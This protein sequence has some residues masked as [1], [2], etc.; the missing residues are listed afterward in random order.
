MARKQTKKQRAASLKNLRKARRARRS[1]RRRASHRPAH[2]GYMGAVVATRKKSRKKS[3]KARKSRKHAYRGRSRRI[4]PVVILTSRHGR[5]RFKRPR[6]SKYFKHPT[7][8]N[9]RRRRLRLNPLPS[10]RGVKGLFNLRTITRYAAI[11]GGVWLGAVVSRFLN[12]G[13][14]PGVATPLFTVPDFLVK[15]RPAHGLI[16]IALGVMLQ[17]K[18]RNPMLKDAGVGLAALGGFDLLMQVLTLAGVPNLPVF[19]GM[20]VSM[21]GANIDAMSGPTVL[22]GHDPH[23]EDSLLSL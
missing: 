7:R 13:T 10:F 22:A 8:I 12:T 23:L 16:H 19:A 21:M 1:R 2:G 15:A 17:R 3:R 14:L 20:N 5:R 18:A 4:R 11:G 6:H 9:R